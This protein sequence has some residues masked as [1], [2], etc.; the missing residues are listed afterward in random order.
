MTPSSTSTAPE[1]L[2]RFVHLSDTHLSADPHYS[3]A[4]ADYPAAAG[5]RA[6]VRAINA[7]PF[8]PDFVLHTG[9]V[10]YDPD[11][12]AYSAARAI[13][14]ELRAPVR[15]LVGNHDD[16]EALQRVLL[17]RHN[18]APKLYEQFECGGVQCILL[19]SQAP[20][21]GAAGALDQPQ[22]DWLRALCAAPDERPLVVAVHHNALPVGAPFF[23]TIMRLADGEALHRALLPAARRLRG[24]FFGHIHQPAETVCDGILYCAAPST[25][26]QLHSDPGSAEMRPDRGARPGFSVV[27]IMRDRTAVRRYQFAVG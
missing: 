7:L 5:A 14:G 1:V 9:D 27:S 19:D 4:D 21:P 15:Y 6:A 17:G 18:P 22:L 10:A 23:D 25:W 16:R 8:T 3:H 13:L 2:L 24:V 20:V 12:A 11:P 26:Y